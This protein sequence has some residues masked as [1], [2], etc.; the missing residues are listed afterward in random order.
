MNAFTVSRSET[1]IHSFYK[2]LSGDY[3][4]PDT[5][6]SFEEKEKKKMD[7]TKIFILTEHDGKISNK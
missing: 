4:M 6:L 1:L 3:R 5:L 2:Y 7:E